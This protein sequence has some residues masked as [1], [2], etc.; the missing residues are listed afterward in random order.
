MGQVPVSDEIAVALARFFYGGAGPSHPAI[1][2][3]ATAAGYGDAD[4]YSPATQTPNKQIRV[5]TV[6][7]AAIRRPQHARRLVDAILVQLRVYGSST[8]SARHMTRLLSG[9]LSRRFVGRLDAHR[10]RRSKGIRRY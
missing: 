4:P 5:H 3:V 1:S 2:G 9:S 10:R 8:R 6:L 7:T